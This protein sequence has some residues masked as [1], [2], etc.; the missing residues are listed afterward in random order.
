MTIKSETELLIHYDF[1][2]LGTCAFTTKRALGRDF[3]RLSKL[4][5]IDESRIIAPHQT[6]SD[7]IL[8]ITPRF[9]ALSPEK[10]KDLL[11]GVDAVYTNIPDVCVGVSTADCI[12]VLLC[13]PDARAVAAIHAGWRG[14]LKRIVMKTVTKIVEALAAKPEDMKAVIGA[15]I[16]RERFETGEEVYDAFLAESFDMEKIA[17]RQDKPH[18]DLPECNR[19]QLLDCGLQPDNV[20]TERLSTYDSPDILFSARREQKDGIKCE[21]NFNGIFL[22]H[23]E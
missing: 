1:S 16:S 7:N 18:I 2:A 14:T 19:L 20:F 11:E 4:I 9:L 5:G 17:A 8:R 21:R 23:K 12:P 10:R 3:S 15:G 6:H 13:C 22:R